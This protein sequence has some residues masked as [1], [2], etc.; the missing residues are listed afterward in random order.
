LREG[1]LGD[2]ERAVLDRCGTGDEGL[3]EAAL[4]LLATKLSGAPLP[5]Q[6]GVALAQRMA[7]EPHPWPRVWAL[8]GRRLSK[9]KAVEKLAEWLDASRPADPASGERRCGV[10]T[11]TRG[12]GTDVTVV[13]TVQAL[14]DLVALPR[15]AR[16]GQWLRVEARLLVAARGGTITV[17]GRSG[18]PRTV[19]TSFDGRALRAQVALDQPG[20]IVVQVVADVA[21]GARPVL[22]AT[23][24]ADIDPPLHVVTAAAPGEEVAAVFPPAD[25]LAE[26]T[27]MARATAALRRLARD[28]RLDAV[29]QAHAERMARLG[30]LAHDVGD[31]DPVARVQRAGIEARDIGE[32]VAA[33]PDVALAHRAIW[34]SPAH[35][36]NVLRAGF[37]A[38]GVGV[39]RD[40]AGQAWVVEL[41]A[42]L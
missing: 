22:E 38:I 35:R 10:A 31:G 28:R 41:F 29:A 26:M 6:D 36:A 24:F 21:S 15:R 12:D 16:T 37:N 34:A 1:E 11:G 9:A 13:V 32:N 7:G 39:A 3:R 30:Q 23:V 20:E 4:A 19:P 14:A 33:A 42:A 8:S 25:A 17:M 5:E 18:I 27:A 40:A 2:V